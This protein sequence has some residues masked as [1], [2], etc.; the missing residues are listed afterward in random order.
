MENPDAQNGMF[1]YPGLSGS[2]CSPQ[3]T[4]LQSDM[5]YSLLLPQS[6]STPMTRLP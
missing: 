1:S 3:N 4:H 5:V 2:Q 6:D